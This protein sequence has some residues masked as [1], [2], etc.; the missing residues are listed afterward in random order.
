M[1]DDPAEIPP[2]SFF[3]WQEA[4]VSSSGMGRDFHCLMCSI[5]H[6]LCRARRRQPRR[7][8]WRVTC[9]NGVSFPLV[10]VGRRGPCGPT[11]KLILLRTHSKI[12][13]RPTK[14]CTERQSF[15]FV[16]VFLRALLLRNS[17]QEYCGECTACRTPGP[18]WTTKVFRP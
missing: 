2:Y 7:L 10:T 14:L 6:F 8:S 11:G 16:V 18:A 17:Q 3:F 1:T 5:R 15:F 13:G 12:V 4:V 9:P